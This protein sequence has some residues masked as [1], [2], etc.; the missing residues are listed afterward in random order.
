MFYSIKVTFLREEALSHWHLF[1]NL[2][3]LRYRS[4]RRFASGVSALWV[5]DRM[6]GFIF[7]LSIILLESLDLQ[8]S[9]YCFYDVKIKAVKIK[10]SRYECLL[11]KREGQ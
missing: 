7:S 11:S 9:H 3:T 1:L 6:S 10:N 4:P 5:D 2:M 8:S